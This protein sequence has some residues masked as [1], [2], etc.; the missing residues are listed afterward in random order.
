MTKHPPHA[1]RK[2]VVL[3]AVL[4]VIVLLS[5]AAYRYA[6]LMQGEYRAAHASG[7]AIQARVIADSGVAYASAL[8]AGNIEQ[9][10][11]GNLWDNPEAFANVEV[12]NAD[13]RFAGRFHIISMASP[14][15]LASNSG[16]PWRFGITDEC[17]KINVN[18][19]LA[20]DKGAGDKGIAM[21]KALGC[22]DEVAAAI[23]DWLDPDGTP[24]PGGA[25]DET[26]STMPVPYKAKNGPLDSIEELLL[27]RGVTADLLFGGDRN[28]NGTLEPDEGGNGEM[29]P[30]GLAAYLTVYS[31]EVNVNSAIPPEQRANINNT[32]LAKLNEQLGSYAPE[33]ATYI[34][35]YRLYGGKV[36][37]EGDK[38]ST[39]AD[40]S[41]VAEK[42][43][44]DLSKPGAKGKGKIRSIWDLTNT[45]VTVSVGSGKEAKSVTFPSPMLNAA[46]KQR[47]LL[48]ALFDNFSTNEK[49]EMTA[50]INVM[51]APS[52]V[53]DALTV[54]AGLEEGALSAITDKRP[55][56]TD[57]AASEP[58]F[59]TPTWLLT[60]ANLTV[61]VLK[62]IEKYITS[63]SQ[64]YRF[65]VLG[66]FNTPGP[67]ARVEA[68]VDGNQGR[69]RVLYW[70][71][72]SEL[73]RGFPIKGEESK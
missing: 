25:E 72:L 15:D 10:V 63:R 17:G 14:D 13:A 19:L 43:Q 60:D 31:R 71:D 12:P 66:T 35:A 59:K 5:L 44:A 57:A 36:V 23:M 9:S 28:R 56:L 68:V 3:L 18:G 11:G 20:L 1:R 4:V 16:R 65:Q 32:D 42:V 30:Q 55:A 34:M 21:L 53:I 64:V 8:L 49:K 58:L 27:V 7:R 50:R 46:D 67:P 48:P 45:A 22:S 37:N 51:T 2:A 70:R 40:M 73:G 52:K 69:P 29:A 62:K 39:D 54:A 26:Y 61:D 24:R 6:D 47:A 38:V 41:A 33:M